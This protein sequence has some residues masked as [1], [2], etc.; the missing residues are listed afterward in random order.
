MSVFDNIINAA[1][2]F[3]KN[4]T[5]KK[6]DE[7]LSGAAQWAL[8]QNGGGRS[9]ATAASSKNSGTARSKSGTGT[10]RTAGYQEPEVAEEYEVA[11]PAA[12]PRQKNAAPLMPDLPS[13]KRRSTA[14]SGRHGTLGAMTQGTQAAVSPEKFV[15][16]Q[17]NR[18]QAAADAYGSTTQRLQVE[19]ALRKG[20]YAEASRLLDEMTG[21][22]TPRAQRQQTADYINSLYDDPSRWNGNKTANRREAWRN[23]DAYMEELQGLDLNQFSPETRAGAERL[24]DAYDR[25]PRQLADLLESEEGAAILE[26]IERERGGQ[27]EDDA[28]AAA[29]ENLRTGRE[30]YLTR[31]ATYD[32][33]QRAQEQVDRAAQSEVEAAQMGNYVRSQSATMALNEL[34]QYL[35]VGGQADYTRI[36]S[37][38]TQEL[39]D[40]LKQYGVNLDGLNAENFR[41]VVAGALREQ[42]QTAQAAGDQLRSA[43]YD[44]DAVEQLL[45]YSR[46]MQQEQTRRER[47]QQDVAGMNLLERAGL[48]LRT[49]AE[50][51]LTAP[52]ESAATWARLATAQG[53]TSQPGS[54]VPQVGR[55]SDAALA[56]GAIADTM[57]PVG[58]F[59]YNAFSSAADS[60]LNAALYGGVGSLANMGATAATQEANDILARGGS[61]RQAVTGGL[62][63]GAIEV[64]TEIVSVENLINIR[65]NPGSIRDMLKS[66]GV[67]MFTEGIEEINSEVLGLIVDGLNMGNLSE[68]SQAV[69]QYT[70]QGM[71]YE[72][73][74]RRVLLDNVKQV[75]MSGLAGAVSGGMSGGA[76]AIG[77]SIGNSLAQRAAQRQ[78]VADFGG[79]MEQLY[80]QEAARR[81]AAQSEVDAGGGVIVP[82]GMIAPYET[83]GVTDGPGS[84]APTEDL[85]A[86]SPRDGET[87][88]AADVA[89]EIVRENMERDEDAADDFDS[90]AETVPPEPEAQ[91]S[92]DE[93]SAGDRVPQVSLREFADDVGRIY[94][95]TAGQRQAARQIVAQLADEIVKTGIVSQEAVDNAAQALEQT[96][97]WEAETDPVYTNLRQE[98]K[99]QRI[100]VSEQ[101]RRELGDDWKQLRQAAQKAGVTLM[102]R[103]SYTAKRADGSTVQREVRGADELFTELAEAYPSLF[104]GENYNDLAS[105]LW[106]FVDAM[107]TG[108]GSQQGYDA[109]IQ[110]YGAEGRAVH[111]GLRSQLM[112]A[113]QS[114]LKNAGREQQY[115][116][117]Y[118]GRRQNR[119]PGARA[120]TAQEAGQRE[121]AMEARLPEV[122]VYHAA[123]TGG[124]GGTSGPGNPATT[125]DTQEQGVRQVLANTFR[126]ATVGDGVYQQIEEELDDAAKSYDKIHELESLNEAAERVETDTR[127]EIEKLSNRDREWTGAD[128]DT[129]ML[130][131]QQAQRDGAYEIAQELAVEAARRGTVAGQMIQALAKWSRTPTGAA[132][133]A[134]SDLTNSGTVDD[135]KVNAISKRLMKNAKDVEDAMSEIRRAQ[136]AQ[137]DGTPYSG[138]Q[139]A[140]DLR[141]PKEKLLNAIYDNARLRGTVGAF[142]RDVNKTIRSALNSLDAADLELIATAQIRAA[143]QDV[144]HK[145]TAAQRVATAQVLSQLS[146]LVTINRNL[147]G[148]FGFDIFD[149]VAGNIGT[150]MDM[151]LGKKTGMRTLT[152]DTGY[153]NAA[154]R[155]GARDGFLKAFCEIALDV[156]TGGLENRYGQSSQRTYKMSGNAFDRFMSRWEKYSGYTLTATDEFFKGGTRESYR[157]RMQKFVEQGKLT[158]EQVDRLAEIEAK[159]RTFQQDDGMLAEMS[160][161]LKQAMNKVGFSGSSY[162]TDKNGKRVY[163]D[164]SQANNADY[165]KELSAQTGISEKVIKDA[166]GGERFGLGNIL[167][168]YPRIP[169]NLASLAI[170]SN[171]VGGAI[172][173]IYT[174]AKVLQAG[175]NV[176]PEM[177]H[178]ASMAFGRWVT[179][180]ALTLA[181]RALAKAGVLLV[182]GA[183]GNDEDK[184]RAAQR[185][186]QGLSGTQLN[187]SGLE[188]MLSGGDGSL[189]DGDTLLSIGF[190]EPLS[191]NMTIGAMMAANEDEKTRLLSA[192]GMKSMLQSSYSGTLQSVLDIPVVENVKNFVNNMTKTEGDYDGEKLGN[193]LVELAADSLSG[194]IP[195][196]IRGLA[197]AM[198]ANYRETGATD[199]RLQQ[200]LNTLQNGIP[201]LREALPEKRDALGQEKRYNAGDVNRWLNSLV[202]P[203]TVSGY[204]ETDV[205]GEL[206]RMYQATGKSLYPSTQAVNAIN[207]QDLTKEQKVAF[208]AERGRVYNEAVGQLLSDP[209]YRNASDEK[210]AEMLEAAYKVAGERAKVA[211]GVGYKSEDKLVGLMD[212]GLSVADAYAAKSYHDALNDYG[213]D[214]GSSKAVLPAGAEN[215]TGPAQWAVAGLGG[216]QT[217]QTAEPYT[218]N[219][220]AAR[221]K[222]WVQ[223]QKWTEAQKQAVLDAYGTYTSMTF[224]DTERFDKLE[225]YGLSGDDSTRIM[226][227]IG[228]LEPIGDAAQVSDVQKWGAIVN[229]ERLSDEQKIAAMWGYMSDDQ[230]A[231]FEIALQ[232]GISASQYLEVYEAKKT[233]GNKNGNWT[234]E[235]LKAY[236]KAG[237]YSENE[238]HW[239]FDAFK[240]NKKTANPYASSGAVEHWTPPEEDEEPTAAEDDGA[241]ELT[242]AARWALAMGGG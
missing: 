134:I 241:D 27:H 141:Q 231:R 53:S 125:G 75:A 155:S 36:G 45:D 140:L 119:Q 179:G 207:G 120:E 23:T 221:F 126:N 16:E 235:T 10:S 79:E 113:A 171:P 117:Q 216:G 192:D 108:K 208:V 166:M 46:Q 130:L 183:G 132:V 122:T 124:Q 54:Y 52:L 206:E 219:E 205:E 7:D 160:V 39:V 98:Y 133:G 184:K 64:L 42:L 200:T 51:V 18:M 61:N 227:A 82:S 198:D 147:A 163:I 118:G 91:P 96:A 215:L 149:T 97:S 65:N 4:R 89:D 88:R 187:L 25:D 101:L 153:F 80:R 135:G 37:E 226:E 48:H 17:K 154:K 162:V 242:G 142:S 239:L 81:Q 2:D 158:Q 103:N 196:P 197:K 67:Q 83:D 93:L 78:A 139:M 11:E 115:A 15:R 217:A 121:A 212:K 211:A 177:Q 127:G 13:G 24:L 178:K 146:S 240:P 77:T 214:E 57:S 33:Y 169:A 60:A 193:A 40:E 32:F 31:N 107:E 56:R 114:F 195:A 9:K 50:N 203:G 49:T 26:G 128:M 19:N 172:N 41:D 180:S 173:T 28:Q 5:Q 44:P 236:L 191:A 20:D 230:Q 123:D 228:D 156:D 185:T 29:W 238:K 131:I 170:Q 8:N 71:S 70:A 47:M 38:K 186:A 174:V 222:N 35:G 224:S 181:F 233:H 94:P 136:E 199:S 151:L 223:G 59:F 165:I 69:Q 43:G 84:P 182:S 99:G 1:T 210:K 209:A 164:R 62:A 190:M 92:S 189:Q 175:K 167:N 143:A 34:Y 90:L 159:E 74:K 63:A 213:K 100:Y 111:E 73:A 202:L 58:A 6:K 144:L 152:T 87:A 86:D 150:A 110:S 137:E 21:A 68:T 168:N 109:Y 234:N 3:F 112:E 66:V 237:N 145:P 116:E 138:E 72:E 14:Q 194:F 104:D 229:D 129:A 105:F 176:S 204:R 85:R 106:K 102:S 161:K 220:K 12:Q 188:R 232:G 157:A 201:G 76:T 55:Q 95:A 218:K 148:N 30:S 225:R 22:N